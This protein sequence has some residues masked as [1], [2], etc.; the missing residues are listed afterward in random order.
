MAYF[1]C[2]FFAPALLATAAPSQLRSA[3]GGDV[4]QVSEA[5]DL[6]ADA[7]F[8]RESGKLVDAAEFAAAALDAL[9]SVD[10]PDS[11]EVEALRRSAASFQL[12]AGWLGGA[13]DVISPWVS[14]VRGS[15]WTGEHTKRSIQGTLAEPSRASLLLAS[16][17]LL[18]SGRYHDALAVTTRLVR[19][20]R[21]IRNAYWTL[22]R[23]T[24][25]GD[26]DVTELPTRKC[27]RVRLERPRAEAEAAD[28]LLSPELRALILGIPPPSALVEDAHLGGIPYTY[29]LYSLGEPE[30]SEDWDDVSLPQALVAHATV[31]RSV[32]LWAEAERA[33]SE[34]LTLLTPAP[35]VRTAVASVLRS[36]V[37][38][39][40]GDGAGDDDDG[41]DEGD[42]AVNAVLAIHLAV[43]RNDAL[44]RSVVRELQY[45]ASERRSVVTGLSFLSN[46]VPSHISARTLL[47]VSPAAMR[48]AA[49]SAYLFSNVR[50]AR[51]IGPDASATN[52]GSVER[53]DADDDIVHADTEREP[54]AAPT[55][56]SRISYYV[57]A[58]AYSWNFA[59]SALGRTAGL[60]VH[61][62]NGSVGLDAPL[63]TAPETIVPQ[64]TPAFGIRF[65]HTKTSYQFH[66][67][68]DTD[69]AVFADAD[70]AASVRNTSTPAADGS[71]REPSDVPLD[72]ASIALDSVAAA[73]QSVDRWL[74][75]ASESDLIIY[76]SSHPACAH[77]LAALAVVHG[78]LGSFDVS[79]RVSTMAQALWRRSLGKAMAHSLLPY[80]R[81]LFFSAEALRGSERL[82]AAVE[83]YAR[84]VEYGT[85]ALAV[86]GNHTCSELDLDGQ[87]DACC[88]CELHDEDINAPCCSDNRN[89]HSA[90]MEGVPVPPAAHAPLIV[91]HPLVAT[92]LS[93]IAVI[94]EYQEFT[95]AASGC[96]NADERYASWIAGDSSLDDDTSQGT[97]SGRGVCNA[98]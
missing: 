69:D 8:M 98:V 96:V 46:L 39:N 94:R 83:A 1:I 3:G 24:R 90:M 10:A 91:R 56:T 92:A 66:T 38:R 9:S 51:Y 74:N 37:G 85:A 84:V 64:D 4:V 5:R 29:A 71:A 95:A 93:R 70:L 52:W 25:D 11:R 88:Q 14:M 40:D 30:L 59:T 17:V 15:R 82:S 61:H 97:P 65:A 21:C 60:D 35:S 2:S 7:Q 19:S 50:R 22:R 87:G 54:E 76:G 53:G 6:L 41:A 63:S 34:A 80:I 44:T 23:S 43:D 68:D 67:A 18:H 26:G 75:D 16:E 13:L 12:D 58:S 77:S 72:T 57:E 47:R 81:T 36:R 32:G 42:A 45:L 33:L 49:E 79:L 28:A 73:T 55:Y 89:A 86:V 20:F 48:A 31:S 62:A 27:P 78:R